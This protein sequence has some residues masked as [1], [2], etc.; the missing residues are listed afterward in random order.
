MVLSLASEFGFGPEAA[1][2][3]VAALGLVAAEC[4]AVSWVQYFLHFLRTL[5]AR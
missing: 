4:V 5:R 1:A 2:P 3:Y